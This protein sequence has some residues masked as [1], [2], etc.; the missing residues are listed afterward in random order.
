VAVETIRRIE[1]DDATVKEAT[2]E[3]VR[4][5]FE[6]AGM[7]FIAENGGGPSVRLRK[8]KGKRK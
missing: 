1:I 8:A 5:A 3:K 4:A 6:K 7:E 2:I